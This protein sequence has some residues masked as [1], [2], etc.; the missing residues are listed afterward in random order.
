MSR[1]K[2]F[3]NGGSLL[4]ADLNSI[5]DDYESAFASYKSGTIERAGS[6]TPALALGTYVIPS[7]N[8]VQQLAVLPV[9]VA[10]YRPF[11]LDPADFSAA[12]RLNKLRLRAQLFTNAVA[13]GTVWTVGLQPVLTFGGASGAE[14]TV[15]SITSTVTGSSV[16]FT[17]PGANTA[18]QQNSGDFTAPA[19]GFYVL[20]VV[21]SAGSAAN[22][23]VAVRAAL[24]VR[25]V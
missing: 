21:N 2:T 10:G 5:Q 11:Y 9:S 20:T 23:V 17:L 1:V 3:T 7:G 12:P 8:G 15:A 18:T 14:P 4:A 6:G 22:S 16:V 25:Q 24:Q 13:P 19:A